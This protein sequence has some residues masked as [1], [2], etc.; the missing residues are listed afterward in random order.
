MAGRV[1][2]VSG[3]G[4]GLGLQIVSHLIG[5]G[6]SVSAFS[7]TSSPALERLRESPGASERLQLATLDLRDRVAV[8]AFVRS[9]VERHGR[10]DALVNNAGVSHEGP[11]A[12]AALDDIDAITDTNLRGTL[13]LVRACLRPML[14]ARRGRI[15]NIS[16]VAG[17]RGYAGLAAYSATKGALDALTRAL[18]RELGPRGIAANSIAPGYLDVG[19]SGRLGDA[20]RR[21]IL[22]RTPLGRLGKPAD[23][24]GVLDFLLS[25]A[26]DFITGQVLVV[27]G[28]LSC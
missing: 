13:H 9:A 8:Q 18:A 24:L 22:G 10:I 5:V 11:L 14:A 12:L 26:A 25:P 6:D 1:V 21:K 2:V 7:R 28:G 23:V 27:D 15:V 17:L 20:Q 16:S 3:A 19:M 4:R